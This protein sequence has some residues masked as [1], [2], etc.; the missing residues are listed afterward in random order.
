[1]VTI[2]VTP[3]VPP[4]AQDESYNFGRNTVGG[5]PADEGVLANDSDA[6]GDHL[7]ATLLTAGTMSLNADGSFFYQAHG[8]AGTDILA[9]QVSDGLMT[10]TA[11]ITI[12]VV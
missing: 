2:H 8:T 1:L 10:T 6:D 9:Y 11:T 4:V 3:D 7:T 5:L 12:N